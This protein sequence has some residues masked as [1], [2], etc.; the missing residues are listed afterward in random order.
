[1]SFTYPEQA[2]AIFLFLRKMAEDRKIVSYGQT[3]ASIG[4]PGEGRLIAPALKILHLWCEAHDK[5]A[6]TA[7]VVAEATGEVGSWLAERIDN[8][9]EE[10]ARVCRHDWSTDLPRLSDLQAIKS[11]H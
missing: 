9:D 8:L 5:P 4:R 3:A 6:I 11:N 7:L 2:A 10:R 1:M